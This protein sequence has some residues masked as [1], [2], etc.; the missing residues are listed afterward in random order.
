MGSILMAVGF[1]EAVPGF[2]LR[3]TT[4]CLPFSP[5]EMTLLGQ[6]GESRLRG[7]FTVCC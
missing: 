4:L 3:N 2:L 5:Q 7:R 6:H 1:S